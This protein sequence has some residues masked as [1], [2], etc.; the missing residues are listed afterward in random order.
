MSPQEKSVVPWLMVCA[1]HYGERI[2][3][4]VRNILESCKYQ[5]V[6]STQKL[7]SVAKKQKRKLSVS[8]PSSP[9]R[10]KSSQQRRV[11]KSMQDKECMCGME[12][13]SSHRW[14]DSVDRLVPE[15]VYGTQPKFKPD[16]APLQQ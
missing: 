5:K 13:C 12:M 11:C 9:F 10:K 14:Q 3:K 8:P 6:P 15:T 7:K 1:W 16:D 2:H 4:H